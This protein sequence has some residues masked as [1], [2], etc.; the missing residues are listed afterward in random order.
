MIFV[1]HPDPPRRYPTA[2][3]RVVA[4]DDPPLIDIDRACLRDAVRAGTSYTAAY[5]FYVVKIALTLLRKPLAFALLLYLL[6]LISSRTRNTL[7]TI[8][9]SVCWVPGIASTPLYYISPSAPRTPRWADYPKLV[10]VQ[11][12]RFEQLLDASAGNLG[13]SLDIKR[14]EIATGDLITLVKV[15]DLKSRETLALHLEGFSSDAKRVGRSLQKL[16][17]RIGGAID[18]CAISPMSNANCTEICDSV[19]SPSTTTRYTL[20]KGPRPNIPA[21]L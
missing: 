11:E 7:H 2:R 14:A 6:S 17:S 8:F 13:I 4:D 15:S 21:R 12:S 16:S 1:A 10:E 9:V 19:S 5:L 20:L 3:A 18:R